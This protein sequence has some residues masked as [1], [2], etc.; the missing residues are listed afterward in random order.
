M[1]ALRIML[2]I[3]LLT[4]GGC[5]HTSMMS[6]GSADAPKIDGDA[7]GT[8]DSSALSSRR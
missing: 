4:G 7:G 8:T 5:S 2:L 3:I 6:S 1:I